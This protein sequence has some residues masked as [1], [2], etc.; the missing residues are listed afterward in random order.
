MT[1]FAF[2]IFGYAAALVSMAII[3]VALCIRAPT[4]EDL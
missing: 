3:F 2:F 4:R 1:A